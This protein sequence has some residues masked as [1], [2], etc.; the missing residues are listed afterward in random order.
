MAIGFNDN[1][2]VRAPKPIDNRY[3]K[4]LDNTWVPFDSVEEAL[5]ATLYRYEGLILPIRSSSNKIELY[6]FEGG[7]ADSNLVLFKP[8]I[9]SDLQAV[10]NI[11]NTTSNAITITGVGKVNLTT[12]G[13]LLFSNN[14]YSALMNINT[15]SQISS[16][17]AFYA[18]GHIEFATGAGNTVFTTSI[19]DANG[20]VGRF[21]G[22]VSGV[23][24]SEPNHFVTLQQLE[25]VID[26]IHLDLNSRIYNST[27]DNSGS[28][29]IYAPEIIN[30]DISTTTGKFIAH[31]GTGNTYLGS[32]QSATNYTVQV[33]NI[34]GLVIFSD[35]L[36]ELDTSIWF[37][38]RTGGVPTPLPTPT[39]NQFTYTFP[40]NLS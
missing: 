20:E 34:N 10:T 16:N 9:V 38:Y 19:A 30:C 28:N 32:I 26:S 37:E 27:V 15:S 14:G 40:F 36:T 7:I 22:R 11:G 39:N 18:N 31:V 12:P 5:T 17:I 13:L 23:D 2:N 6:W 3:G 21:E 4:L 24:A 25:D 8:L 1:I 35:P 33:D 29:A